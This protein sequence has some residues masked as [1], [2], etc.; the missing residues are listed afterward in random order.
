MGLGLTIA[1]G[2]ASVLGFLCEVSYYRTVLGQMVL[3]KQDAEG[4][5]P[6]VAMGHRLQ[7]KVGCTQSAGARKSL[8][9]TRARGSVRSHGPTACL[10]ILVVYFCSFLVWFLFSCFHIKVYVN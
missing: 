9:F 10:Q 5:C 4:Q 8:C 6:L 7:S 2:T 3:T 1:G